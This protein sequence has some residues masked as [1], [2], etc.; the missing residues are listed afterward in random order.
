M[1][2]ASETAREGGEQAAGG[3]GRWGKKK[4]RGGKDKEK[5]KKGGDERDGGQRGTLKGT[6]WCAYRRKVVMT[7]RGKEGERWRGQE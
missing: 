1:Q 7:V 2:G 5:G 6:G 3:T 4:K